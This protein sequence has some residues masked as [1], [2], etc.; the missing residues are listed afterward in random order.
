MNKGVEWV[1]TF[2]YGPNNPSQ[3]RDFLVE[4]TFV[5][6]IWVSCGW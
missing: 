2:V 4:L 6:G 1:A 3:R 5:A